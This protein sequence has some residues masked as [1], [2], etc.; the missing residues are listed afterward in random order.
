MTELS[1]ENSSKINTDDAS[2]MQEDTLLSEE[3]DVLFGG[4]FNTNYAI[5]C[6]LQSLNKNMTEIGGIAQVFKTDTGKLTEP[7][8]KR[9]SPSAGDDSDSEEPDPDKL[10]ATNKRQKFVADWSNGSMCETSADETSDSLLDEIAQSLT[11]TEKTA[12]C[13]RDLQRS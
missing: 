5:L 3:S 13:R 11:D 12:P 10:L 8:K 4:T 2:S 7:A 1:F 6:V 9:K